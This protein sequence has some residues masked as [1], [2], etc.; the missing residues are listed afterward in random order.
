MILLNVQ[1]SLNLN[2]IFANQKNVI[3]QSPDTRFTIFLQ[4]IWRSL[5]GLRRS[6]EKSYGAYIDSEILSNQ[7]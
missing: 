7:F 6:L 3:G 2:P 4:L 1:S 5:F